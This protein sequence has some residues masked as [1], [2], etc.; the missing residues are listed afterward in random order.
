[1]T[2]IENKIISI[3]DS[4]LVSI[5]DKYT[6]LNMFIVEIDGQFIQSWHEYVAAIQDAFKFPTTCF[7]SIDRYL[8]WMRDLSWLNKNGFVLIIKNY[9]SFMHN[10]PMLKKEL[11]N[12]FKMIILPFWEQ[13]VIFTVVR[14]KPKNF[15]VYLVD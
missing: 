2:V 6:K 8:D 7:D 13:E 10:N 15:I 4:E 5:R 3:L 11:F 14:G 1:M 12:D 9:K